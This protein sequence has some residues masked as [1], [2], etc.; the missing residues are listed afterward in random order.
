VKEDGSQTSPAGCDEDENWKSAQHVNN[1]IL[2]D[3][4]KA[5][6]ETDEYLT[7]LAKKRN[8]T[9]P[10]FQAI[11]LR[12]GSLTEDPATEKVLMEKTTSR[13]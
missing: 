3:Y 5:K 9:D 7:A 11:N 12:P 6:V 2:P 1:E 13:G 8:E 4:Y 10:Q